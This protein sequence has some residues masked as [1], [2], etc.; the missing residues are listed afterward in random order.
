MARKYA[1]TKLSINDDPDFEGLSTEAQWLYLRVMMTDPSLSACGVMDWRP[2]RML[3][4]SR[5][6]TLKKLLDAA[7]ELEHARFALFDLDTEEALIRTFVRHDEPLK[8]PKMAGAVVN[9][10]QSIASPELRA[11]VV[12]E[13][14]R[15]FAEH[16]D[17]SSWEH[18]DTA[19]DLARIRARPGLGEVEY[20]S[21]YDDFA[22]DDPADI[23][24][25]IGYLTGI[26]NGDPTPIENGY[27][28]S[29]SKGDVHRGADRQ[30]K[31]VDYLPAPTPTTITS[32]HSGGYVTGERHQSGGTESPP[33]G[34]PQHPNG[35]T[36]PCGACGEIRRARERFEVSAARLQAEQHAAEKREAAELK[37]RAVE[38]CDICDDE[39]YHRRHVC[40]HDPAIENAGGGKLRAAYEA[41]RAKAVT[42]A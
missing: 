27:P 33:L 42:D 14:A 1:R 15:E 26:E 29:V 30:S 16:P 2:K 11:A 38:A 20:I 31:S 40:T 34:C 35:T 12:T 13:I 24:D 23:A 28:D 36:A 37:A 10:Y 6:I 21:A 4:K 9:A 39:G 5:T 32:Q 19:E 7:A 18:K 17:Y 41:E 22:D 3:R 8:N 25:R